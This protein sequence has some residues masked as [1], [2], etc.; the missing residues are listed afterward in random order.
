VEESSQQGSVVLRGAAAGSLQEKLAVVV[1]VACQLVM[2]VAKELWSRASSR[3]HLR[4]W[5]ESYTAR[6]RSVNALPS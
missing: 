3:L 1:A 2:R 5:S 6:S 4:R